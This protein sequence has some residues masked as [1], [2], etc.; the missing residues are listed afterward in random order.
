MSLQVSEAIYCQL[1][2]YRLLRLL[3]MTDL[4]NLFIANDFNI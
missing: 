4:R 3:P 1:N 2:I